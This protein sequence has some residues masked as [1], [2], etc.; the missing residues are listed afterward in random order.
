MCSEY[1]CLFSIYFFNKCV[2]MSY[3]FTWGGDVWDH[4]GMVQKKGRVLAAPPF[5]AR[6]HS[7]KIVWIGFWRDTVTF[8]IL[9]FW[10]A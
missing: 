8:F 5:L 9:F 6:L 3:P 2:K 10:F 1:V 4:P 7:Q